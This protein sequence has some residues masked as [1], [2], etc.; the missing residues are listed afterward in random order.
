VLLVAI[1]AVGCGQLGL[2]RDVVNSIRLVAVPLAAIGVT[3]WATLAS[4]LPRTTRL[5]VGYG[6]WALMAAVMLLVETENNGDMDVVGWKWRWQAARDET[7]GTLDARGGVDEW[8][9]TP[10]DYPRFL[11]TGYWAEVAEVD[12]ET[13]WQSN[14]PREVWRTEIGA[15]WPGFAVVG[16]YA[17]TQEQ[18]GPEELVTCYAVQTGD[19][20]WKHADP[21][22]WEPSGFGALGY[23]GPRATP[24][25]FEAK[26]YAQG[27]TGIVNCLDARSGDV[28]WSH[29]T[30]EE[31]NTEPVLWGKACS[32]LV[33]ERDGDSALVVISVGAPK[34]RSVIAYDADTGA[35]IWA[36]G[37]RRS[38]YASPVLTT[39][40]GVE[41]IVLVNEGFVTAHRADDG[42]V[43]WEHEWPG[44]SDSDASVSQPVPVGGDR[45]FLSKG[46]GEGAMLLQLVGDEDAM[47]A[48]IVWK[49]KL[50]KTKMG[51]VVIRDGYVYGLDGGVMQCIELS[52]GKKQW[53]K[54]RSPQDIGHGQIMLIGD[55][56]L[57]L[58]ES[59][60]VILIAANPEK[61]EELASF[62]AFDED[63]VT[64]NN[65]AFAPPY[66]LIRNAEQAACYELPLVGALPGDSEL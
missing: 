58:S 35:E 47:Q 5:L 15:G 2:T 40:L 7:L 14:P 42:T 38:S 34:G 60:E 18:R 1:L 10:G 22:R 36:A 20:V 59:G 37:D 63:Q 9:V 56:I 66:L 32:P 4:G 19:V 44:N 57:A 16:E 31:N 65:P 53:K 8:Q 3:V 29:D 46:Y 25:I 21:V 50:M 24:T 62:R 45:V 61:F 17:V 23:A 41:Q 12:L 39:L 28:V 26:V 49:K 13:D 52:T 55:T 30:M 43:L 51:N 6:P 11:G 54:R 64:W 33:V 48:E 27:A